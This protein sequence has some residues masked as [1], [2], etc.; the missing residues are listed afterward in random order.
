MG[1]VVTPALVIGSLAY[2]VT[3]AALVVRDIL[4]LR[5]LGTIASIGFILANVISPGGPTYVFL[6]WSSMFLAINVFQISSLIVERRNIQLDEED[7]DL[8]SFVFPNLSVGEFRLLMKAGRRRDISE[9]VVLAEQGDQ[10]AEVML[11]ERGVVQLRR[12]GQELD[13]LIEGHMLGEVAFVSRR[14]FSS[15]AVVAEQTRVVVWQRATL[16]RLFLRRP[17]LAIGFHAAFIGQLRRG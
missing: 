12:D 2:A 5:L 7:Q 3:A 16:D 1:A 11:I 15:R 8:H 17:S 4:W 14:P 10:G 9:G 13:R 6:A